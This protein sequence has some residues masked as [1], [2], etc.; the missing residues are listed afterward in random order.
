M[1]SLS[2]IVISIIEALKIKQIVV[3]KSKTEDRKS[4]EKKKRN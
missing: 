4:G 3:A 1:S 2:E